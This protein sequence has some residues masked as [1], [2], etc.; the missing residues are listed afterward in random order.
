MVYVRTLI[1][2]LFIG[3]IP[4]AAFGEQGTDKTV[5]IH[6]KTVPADDE[7]RF[8][9]IARLTIAALDT[10]HA[11]IMLFDGDGAEVVRLG[12]WYGGDTTLLDK[13]DIPG[14]QRESLA[15]SL[16]LSKAS[17]PANYGDLMRLLRGKGAELYVSGDMM[18]LH[19]I[20]DAEYDNV[21]NPVE[22]AG[23]LEIF[24]RADVYLSY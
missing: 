10:G 11:V 9:A 17:T 1:I 18:R 19:Q 22:P 3:M 4:A 21:F 12:S 23:M 24:G 13:L 20:S 14:A 5:V 6:V 15:G 8:Y 16:G 7:S 2:L